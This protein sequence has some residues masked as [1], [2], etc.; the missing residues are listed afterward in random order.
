MLHKTCRIVTIGDIVPHVNIE[1][2]KSRLEPLH[3]GLAACV[4]S[5][6]DS[7]NEIKSLHPKTP[8]AFGATARATAIH[9]FMTH[10]LEAQVEKWGLP[11]VSVAKRLGFHSL[12]IGDDILLR[13]KF[14]GSGSPRNYP[15]DQQLLISKQAFTQDMMNALHLDGFEGPPT[16]LSLG[17]RWMSHDEVLRDVVVRWDLKSYP[18]WEY[19]IYGDGGAAIV[20]LRLPSMP[21]IDP[22]IVRSIHD[23]GDLRK[24]KREGGDGR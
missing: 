24:S 1:E 13:P 22:V 15:T 17:Y 19:S 16:V 3:E 20:P 12:R 18:S 11:H 10:E 7:W 5:A 21:D 9:A 14:L 4:V 23:V 8:I 6:I 2:A